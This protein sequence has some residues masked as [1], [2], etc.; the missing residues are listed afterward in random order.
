[1]SKLNFNK[2]IVLF[3]SLFSCMLLSNDIKANTIKNFDI[4]LKVQDDGIIQV[5][6]KLNVYFDYSSH[7]IYA[8]IPSNYTM[9]WS[10]DDVKSY[11]FPVSDIK[12]KNFPFEV[13]HQFDGVL[14]QIGDADKYIKGNQTFEYSYQIKTRDLGLAQ[15]QMLY[16]D[17]VGSGWSLPIEKVS[18]NIEMPKNF[19]AKP[20]FFG[21]SSNSKIQYTIKDNKIITGSMDSALSYGKALTIKLDLPDNYFDYP[22]NHLFN[23]IGLGIMVLLL[24]V[25]LVFYIPRRR[26]KLTPVIEFKAPNGLS[27]AQLSYLYN[28]G[29]VF[30]KMSS[31]II[32]WASKG[33]LSIEELNHKKQLYLFTK[34]KDIDENEMYYEKELFNKFF[35]RDKVKS[36]KIP[37]EFSKSMATARFPYKNYFENEQPLFNKK[38]IFMI[39]LLTFLTSFALGF[40]TFLMAYE[41]YGMLVY[42]AIYAA[43]SFILSFIL[44]TWYVSIIDSLYIKKTFKKI[45][46]LIISYVLYL[47]LFLVFT[48]SLHEFDA[49]YGLLIYVFMFMSIIFISLIRRRSDEGIIILERILGLKDFINTAE[50]ERLEELVNENPEYFYEI[51]PYAYVL[52]VSNKWSKKFEGISI[53][54]PEWYDSN[55]DVIDVLIISSLINNSMNSINNS[56]TSSFAKSVSSGSGGFSSGGG[57]TSG[58]GFGGG[59]GGSW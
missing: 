59:G 41:Y 9:T 32:Y 27:S 47:V 38:N 8:T 45:I 49:N 57:G 22:T 58:G 20:E 26:V 19:S 18:F 53:P 10:K 5:Y 15:K 56:I 37:E 40:Y 42:A 12:V 54:K 34:I 44:N 50:K 43:I 11:Y 46:K 31:L 28:N 13:D 14:I 48:V 7:G 1:M 3:I 30:K 29:V 16:Y 24:I 35:K 51:L 33:Y 25:S 39:K 2:L 55:I 36:D 21:P 4:N 52:D 17:L 23:I 6:Q